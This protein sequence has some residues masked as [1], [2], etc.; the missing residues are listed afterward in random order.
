[1]DPES[2]YDKSV[3][4]IETAMN[5]LDYQSLLSAHNIRLNDK[6]FHDAIN[7]AALTML[8]RKC[9]CVADIG[10][11]REEMEEVIVDVALLP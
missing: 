5:G 11:I 9:E 8:V 6:V 4:I 10:V 7:R 1:M 2:D 3:K